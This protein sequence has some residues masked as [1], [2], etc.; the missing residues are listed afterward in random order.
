MPIKKSAFLSRR[1]VRH[2]LPQFEF[3]KQYFLIQSPYLCYEK[4]KYME[5]ATVTNQGSYPPLVTP[6]TESK[7][8]I[9]LQEKLKKTVN[10]TP[11]FEKVLNRTLE[12][13]APD[14]M[15]SIKEEM[16]YNIVN[17]KINNIPIPQHADTEFNGFR[18]TKDKLA[19][20]T[21]RFHS[22]ITLN[23]EFKSL[24]GYKIRI[25][26]IASTRMKA[27]QFKKTSYANKSQIKKIRTVMTDVISKKISQMKSL[28]LLTNGY[29]M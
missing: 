26:M 23:H 11:T 25:F 5:F 21:K 27:L 24:D 6:I 9:H 4:S 14:I 3:R 22:T 10:H 13:S 28:N 29:Q 2:R 18:L 16:N 12:V 17:L 8:T 20:L 1:K 15:P 19:T 7:H